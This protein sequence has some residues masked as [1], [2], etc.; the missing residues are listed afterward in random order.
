MANI[1]KGTISGHFVNGILVKRVKPENILHYPE[2]S[3]TFDFALYRHYRSYIKA[4]QVECD[5]ET[6]RLSR[7]EFEKFAVKY[8]Y[9]NGEGYRVPVRLWHKVARQLHLDTELDNMKGR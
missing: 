8:D 7:D 5:G 3:F 1:E 9:G 2:P 4:L 6:F